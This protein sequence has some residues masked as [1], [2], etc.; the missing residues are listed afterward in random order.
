MYYAHR[1]VY[2]DESMS[3][4]S[5][6]CLVTGGASFIG[7]H[8]VE[9]LLSRGASV[10]VADNL[11]SGKRENL[12][13]VEADVE[14][15]VGDLR[16]MDFA[17]R[18]TADCDVVFHLAA[19]HGG[20]GY[21]AT[22]PANCAGNMALDNIVFDS[23]V[24]NDVAQIT[25]ASSACVYPTDIQEERLLLKESMVSFQER[26]GAFA[27][28]EY[29]WAKLMGEMALRAYHKQYGTKAASARLS[30]VYG[31]RENE[32]HALVAL[33]AKAFIQQS[34]F[35]IWGTGEQTRGFTYV[36][37]I[38]E[39]IILASENIEDGSAV[40]VGTSEYI[41][42]NRIAEEIFQVMDWRPEAGIRHLVGKPVGVLHR[43][44][45]GALALQK[46]GWQPRTFLE[47]G[48]RRTVDWYVQNHDASEVAQRL[49]ELLMER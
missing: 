46:T 14:L 4:T 11:S 36:D 16:H 13:D 43:A 31:P 29:G 2:A 49:E 35:E 41:S 21:I 30:T 22:H 34:P 47:D 18:A 27:D 23:A 20:R 37:D 44:L 28:E 42:L 45:D 1:L 33:I 9:S 48:V 15:I 26:G 5:S 17:H 19:D 8:L 3:W 38:V 7:S 10:R 6:K 32:S 12:S 39:G 40:N 24:R 25:F